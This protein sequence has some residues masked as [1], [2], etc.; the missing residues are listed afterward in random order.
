M[1]SMVL[2]RA[3]SACASFVNTN[4]PSAEVGVDRSNME[5][6]EQV[7][8]SRAATRLV[9]TEFRKL[10]GEPIGVFR[11]PGRV[12]LIG[13]HTDYNDGFVMPAALVFGTYVAAGPR[14]DRML[15]V[16]SIDFDETRDFDLD[17]LAP[18]PSGHWSDYVR[19]VA[20]VLQARGYAIR[21]AH[22]VIK[23]DVP[24][25][26]GL[27]SSAALE[28]ATALALLT[29]SGLTWSGLEVA[30]ACQR[31]EHE[32]AGTKCGIMD[33]FISV[34]GKANHAL[35]LDCRSLDYELLRIEDGVRIVVCN[36]M[37]KHEL[38]SGEYNLRRADCEAGV[39]FLQQFLPEIRALRDVSLSQLE[40]Y[41]VGLS[42]ITYKRCRHIISENAR[43]LEAANSL[44]ECNLARFGVLMGES[45][46]SLR[47][48]YEVSCKE[49]DLLVDLAH[50][51]RG[52]YGAR[53]TGGGFGGCTV[54]LL[55]AD[56]VEEFTATITQ[57]YKSATGLRPAI[58]SCTAGDGA[59]EITNLIS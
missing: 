15:R 33:Q 39:R 45:H 28:V 22:L 27:S 11:A 41:G 55:D 18:G 30:L 47:D 7:N 16:H 31:A 14:M 25:G 5:K 42:D 29:N 48:D 6:S 24:I 43:V 2:R 8:N 12:N 1:S 49:L 38:A 9:A 59:G 50:Q 51:C 56:V 23:G 35:L 3:L 52:V 13:E 34:F 58:Y 17:K 21:G 54:N 4:G 20:G 40:Q 37:V 57:E 36:T 44:K 46:L 32:Y 19:G 53:M 10:Y 26:A